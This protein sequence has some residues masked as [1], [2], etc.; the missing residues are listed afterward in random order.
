MFSHF[1]LNKRLLKALD[2]L[3]LTT[4][5]PVQQQAIPFILAGKDMLV[6]A[7]T[8]SGKTAAFL[9]PM[10]HRFHETP[11]PRSVTRALVLVPTRELARQV[12]RQCEALA[13]YTLIKATV[14]IGGDSFK[15][16]AA[17]LRKNPDIVIATPGR[18]AEHVGR[19]TIDLGDLEVLVLDEADRM[20]DMGFR[21]DVLLIAG[22]SR[23]ERQTL[24]FSAT[25]RQ[26][27]L[28]DVITAVLNEP[29]EIRLNDTRGTHE[30][31][32]QQIILA[33]DLKHK[34][35]LLA[36][37][38]RAEIG[39]KVV[40]FT[41]TRLQAD[42]LGRWLRYHKHKVGV[43]HGDMTQEER[44]QV[45][46]FFR[47]G[48]MT[49]LVATDLA[50]RGLDVKGVTL[51]VNLDMARGGDDYVHR[52]G[53]TGR[54]GEQ[55]L[56]VTFIS[57]SEWNLMVS[58]ERYLGATFERRVIKGLEGH[59]KGPKKLKA[60]GKAAGRKKKLTGKKKAESAGKLKNR[61]KKSIGKRRKPTKLEAG[62]MLDV[63]FE[64]LK[65]R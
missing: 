25:M 53:R 17:S 59:Y 8:G 16:Q 65:K 7:E 6:G 36:A 37:L 38:L 46:H 62:S 55:G 33:D 39:E 58:I 35:K 1:P 56:A 26:K 5:T 40:V 41:N 23:L 43:L 13:R 45:I 10:L 24:L 3:S 4:P 15:Y 50:A 11:S 20:L 18:L 19:R 48:R 2:A 29:E 28:R 21:D 61:D 31:I 22:R 27:G 32:K 12:L 51:V 30:K 54:A 44:N 9:L 63:G 64:P 52:I 57:P 42:K 14:I 34:E 60:S 49:V 47:E